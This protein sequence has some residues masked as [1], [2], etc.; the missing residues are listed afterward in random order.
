MGGPV[1]PI[2]AEF[3]ATPHE[4]GVLSMTT[5]ATPI[6]AAH[7]ASSAWNVSRTWI[8][9]TR[10]MEKPQTL[11]PWTSSRRSVQHEEP[12]HSDRPKQPVTINKMTVTVKAKG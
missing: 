11:Q 9:N 8:V 10:L 7:N 5:A 4:P 3:N 6:R 12:D 1:T 2:K